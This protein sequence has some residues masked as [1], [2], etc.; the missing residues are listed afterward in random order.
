M[1]AVRSDEHLGLVAQATE[2]DRVDQPVAIALEYVT[3]PARAEVGFG[4][5]S[6]A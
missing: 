3:R 5:K 4:V 1:I 6:A 2:R